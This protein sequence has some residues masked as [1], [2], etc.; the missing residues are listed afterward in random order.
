MDTGMSALSYRSS[1]GTSMTLT[2]PT[3]TY[4]SSTISP[5][6]LRSFASR[7]ALHQSYSSSA[8]LTT[9]AGATTPEKSVL[10]AAEQRL[11]YQQ[12][13]VD[14]TAAHTA[15]TQAGTM[16][17]ESDLKD[18]LYGRNMAAVLTTTTATATTDYLMYKSPS[19][20]TSRD[21]LLQQRFDP[22]YARPRSR[23]DHQNTSRSYHGFAGE[24]R[25]HPQHANAT[26]A[27]H[28]SPVYNLERYCV[29]PLESPEMSTAASLGNGG[30]GIGG[31]VAWVD[32]PEAELEEV[33]TKTAFDEGELLIESPQIPARQVKRAVSEESFLERTGNLRRMSVLRS[34]GV[35]LQETCLWSPVCC[36]PHHKNPCALVCPNMGSNALLQQQLQQQQQP[37]N[38]EADV[39]MEDSSLRTFKGKFAPAMLRSRIESRVRKSSE[40]Q[41]NPYDC[42]LE[43]EEPDAMRV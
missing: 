40:S 7:E 5:P 3:S 36:L 30:V 41:R 9:I 21:S 37:E 8:P 2:T 39:G 31:G 6:S 43:V 1:S 26:K 25:T 34:K 13:S 24:L 33:C 42:S 19:F 16:S 12:G 4:S 22:D 10:A 38:A 35:G 11:K 15:T 23:N 20:S 27:A 28:D 18:S 29:D 17:G 32:S 14:S